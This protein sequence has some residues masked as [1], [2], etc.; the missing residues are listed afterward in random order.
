MSKEISAMEQIYTIPVNEAF[1]A[2][3]E[4]AEKGE[5]ECPFCALRSKLEKEETERIL[6]A[7]MMEPDTRILTN[8]QGFCERHSGMLHEGGKKLPLA[9]MLESHLDT[10]LEGFR[11]G[12]F[13]SKSGSAAAKKFEAVS[14]DCYICR[15]VDTTFLHMVETAAL[16]WQTDEKFREKCG[17]TGHFCFPHFSEFLTQAKLRLS[18]KEFS[19][20]FTTVGKK[21]GEYLEKIKNDVSEFCRSFDYRNSGELSEDAKKSVETALAFLNPEK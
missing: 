6:G 9:L 13:P 8:E 20:F 2:A 17:K 21:E 16:L 19:S 4:K 3:A 7:A 14:H 18:S 10:L 1:E 12:M 5:A 11:P 15:R